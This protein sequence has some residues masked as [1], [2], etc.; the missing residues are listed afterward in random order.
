MSTSPKLTTIEFTRRDDGIAVITLN[1]P[2][3]LNAIN[4]QM[5]AEVH[6]VL[7]AVE[8]EDALRVVV[9]HGAGRAFCSG[10][11][12]KDDAAAQPKGVAA[13]RRLLRQDFD[14]LIRFWDLS[15]PTIAA[16]HG[17]CLAGGCELAMAC[18][19]TIAAESAMFG[20][21]ELRFGSVITALVMPWLV[22]PKHTK[23]LLLTGQDRIPAAWAEKIGLVNRTVPDD[24]YLD[25]AMSLAGQIARIDPQAVAMT[26][27]SIN[28]TFETMGLREA[29]RANLD[30]AVQIENLDTFERKQF[31]EITRRDGL[32]AA[33]AWRDA[34]F[35]PHSKP[36]AKE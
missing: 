24:N 33:I 20:E 10:F 31:Q 30:V 7:D 11:D 13:W 29:L 27:Q 35:D 14:F 32:K 36:A 12:L 16:V 22:G 23:E 28:R 25:A 21:P 6:R 18:D 1:R 19:I 15:K 4:R 17:Y 3:R 26:K 5:I 8:A 34:R 2:Q 9:V